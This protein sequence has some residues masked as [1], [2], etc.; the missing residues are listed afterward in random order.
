M[1]PSMTRDL[2]VVTQVYAAGMPAE[3]PTR[4]VSSARI[5]RAQQA[6]QHALELRP[7]PERI[8]Q[9][10]AGNAPLHRALQR[11]EHTP[12]GGVVGDDVEQQVNVVVRH[13]RCRRSDG[14]S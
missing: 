11:G 2:A 7:R 8:C 4:M 13:A 3:N 10:A 6:R 12:G 14:R 1:S 9:H 5:P